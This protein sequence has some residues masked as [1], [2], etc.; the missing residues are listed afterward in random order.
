MFEQAVSD[1]RK[2][3]QESGFL[4]ALD[5]RRLRVDDIVP[6]SV[7]GIRNDDVEGLIGLTQPG[8]HATR[9]VV[10]RTLFSL[11]SLVSIDRDEDG[12]SLDLKAVFSDF[13]ESVP[14]VD[15]FDPALLRWE[16]HV[17][18]IVRSLGRVI[19]LARRLEAVG[20]S[21]ETRA[22][23]ARTAFVMI[24]PS[25]LGWWEDL[26]SAFDP[27]INAPDWHLNHVSDFFTYAMATTV[28]K[29]GDWAWTEPESFSE[30]VL[31]A[32]IDIDALLKR[33]QT[34]T[35]SLTPT[36]AAIQSWCWFAQ[37]SA[38]HDPGMLNQA[39]RSYQTL[40]KFPMG[41]D[42]DL[43]STLPAAT[44]CF[45]LASNWS[46]AVDAARLWV[47]EAPTDGKA[48]RRLAEAHYKLGEIPEALR[49]FEECLGLSTESDDD[50]V[51]SMA[52]KMG[53]EL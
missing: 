44:K 19:D 32:L 34:T 52:L 7:L 5:D 14:V 45:G 27:I 31:D 42:R 10:A 4:P 15:L 51:S 16:V 2:I 24:H 43:T 50:W 46:A 17:A 26:P 40:A 47:S 22:L 23:L 9:A 29:R 11:V 53:L 48:H 8:D 41:I 39:G 25:H 49:A 37:G 30:P 28:E 18:A 6:L 13:I 1:A 33:V 12:E 3:Q 38:A 20:P 35:K 21:T 36:L